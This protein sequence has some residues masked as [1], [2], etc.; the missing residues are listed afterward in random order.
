MWRV[1]PTEDT[2]L[3]LSKLASSELTTTA[4][5]SLFVHAYL[6]GMVAGFTS[7][8]SACC[9]IRKLCS[10]CTDHTTAPM[11]GRKGVQVSKRCRVQGGRTHDARSAQRGVGAGHRKLQ[12]ILRQPRLQ[13][14]PPLT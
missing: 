14:L 7:S 5:A 9:A 6:P 11:T 13:V 4:L 8:H 10:T 3:L 12:G 2:L 1:T